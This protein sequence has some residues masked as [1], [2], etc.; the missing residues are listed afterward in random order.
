MSTERT[1]PRR[2]VTDRLVLRG[3]E[4]ADLDPFAA[5]NDD[6]VVM[7]HFARHGT[8][9]D[10]ERL[11]ARVA[12]HW[13]AEGWGLWALERRDTGEF[14]GFTGLWPVA[15]EA[16]FEP[17]REVGWR[18]AVGH[19]GQGFATEAARAALDVAFD[20]LGWADV[21]SFTAVGNERSQAVMRRIGMWRDPV[22]DFDHPDVPEGHPVRP[23]VLYR[24]AA[25]QRPWR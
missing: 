25:D 19:W 6:P 24:L 23:H 8:R 22:G 10:T 20:V 12:A 5:M 2:V 7:E 3:F 11:V 9:E 14:I 13:D 1:A 21:V 18:L 4:P 17:R 16:A 15:F